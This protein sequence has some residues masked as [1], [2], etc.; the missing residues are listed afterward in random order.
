MLFWVV[1]FLEFPFLCYKWRLIV[2]GV[3]SV[4][5]LPWF[6]VVPG[7]ILVHIIL[8]WILH[9]LRYEAHLS[10]LSTMELEGLHHIYLADWLEQHWLEEEALLN[11][12]IS[13]W[14]FR[15]WYPFQI[16]KFVALLVFVVSW[17]LFI[18]FIF[19]IL[20]CTKQLIWIFLAVIGI[21][22]VHSGWAVSITVLVVSLLQE[23]PVTEIGRRCHAFHLVV[24]LVLLALNVNDIALVLTV[25]SI[26]KFKNWQWLRVHLA[27]VRVWVLDTCGVGLVG[28][29]LES[30]DVD[31][32][33]KRVIFMVDR[34][35]H[36][37]LFVI[38]AFLQ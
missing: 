3:N 25:S 6:L 16:S 14:S 30:I 19:L 12:L 21:V 4:F 8:H 13:K 11:K 34:L 1:S 5:T 28:D 36:E 31:W 17:T 2:T 35:H 32:L 10:V 33:G 26:L 29:A 38:L 9:C 20:D 23:E 24:Q 27:V 37:V 18:F 7:L 15:F 22:K